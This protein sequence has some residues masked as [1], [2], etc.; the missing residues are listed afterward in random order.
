MVEVTLDAVLFPPGRNDFYDVIFVE[1]L[2]PAVAA[3]G[4]LELRNRR[5]VIAILAAPQ[6][7]P[8]V[9]LFAVP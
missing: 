1:T 3:D 7:F 9:T 4:V 2:P 5:L 6:S 8:S